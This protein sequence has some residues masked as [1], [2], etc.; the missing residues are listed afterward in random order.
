MMHA[1]RRGCVFSALLVAAAAFF[2][3]LAGVAQAPPGQD[4]HREWAKDAKPAGSKSCEKC[5]SEHFQRWQ[6][7]AHSKMVQ[8][9]T[10]QTVRGDFTT[11][12][13]LRWKGYLYRMFIRDGA[14]FMEVSPPQGGKTTYHV[15]Y[16]V[17]S[18]RVQGYMSRMS[19]G[20]LYLLPA[21]WRVATE[22]WF[23]SSLITPH[24]GE[25]VGVKQFWNTN[26]LACH[27]TDL[28]FDFD[29]GTKTYSTH[30]LE[31]AIGCEACHNPGS[32]HN[33]F[34]E[35][36]PLRDYARKELNDTFISNQKYFDYVRSTELCASCHGS[37]TNYFLGYWPGDRGFDYYAPILMDFDSPDQQGDFYPDGHPTRFN[38]F[39]EFMG[40]RCF[41]E[42]KATC[43]SCHDGHSSENDSLLLVPKERSN[44]LCLNCHQE[45][46]GGTKL[47]QHTF[48]LPDSPGSRCYECHMGETLE[49]LMMHRKDHS[50]DNPVPENTIRYGIPNACNQSRCHGDRTPEWAAK[51][52]DQW[53][54]GEKRK[55][56]LYAAE[57]MWLAKAGDARAVPLL[58]RAVGDSNLR[59][60][61]RASAA[62][63]LARQ[64]GE[65]A[66]EAVPALVLQ[67][68]ADQ[69]LL[70]IASAEAL[71]TLHDRRAAGPLTRLLGDSA[72]VVRVTAAAALINMNILEIE[73][74]EGK[75]LR[76][77]KAEYVQMLRNWPNVPE[78]RLNLASYYLL[79]SRPEEALAESKVA[80]QLNP[81][82]PQAYYSLGRCY[83]AMQ[84]WRDALEA[85]K[86][87]REIK[88][89]FPNLERL[90]AVTEQQIR[91]N[92]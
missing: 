19:D 56:L 86:K 5:H 32:K 71:G 34:F 49:R 68:S 87:L 30:W 65:R 29:P 61:M 80:L 28:R 88:P 77:A 76:Q 44:V 66:Q 26:C 45:K 78:F 73:G 41:L 36:K 67:L 1:S 84:R 54:G 75:A 46:Y 47:T 58:V 38:H 57:A 21:Y 20:R 8:L 24:T 9:P 90:I 39:L 37:K 14:Y 53:Y 3:G 69:P 25:G 59:L 16:T 85:W 7:S 43:V 51:T 15:D 79:H 2:A 55:K 17:G 22:S 64:F 83:V 74:D 91:K 70:R 27:A 82:M 92:Q 63:I 12:N 18:K 89:D 11:D 6:D 48:H 10:P 13:T 81:D 23:D 72:R 50:L 35:K 4:P 60:N 62:R 52:L 31:L 33:E 42:G 40:S